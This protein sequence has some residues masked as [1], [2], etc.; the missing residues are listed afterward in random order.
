MGA[1]VENATGFGLANSHGSDRKIFL[2]ALCMGHFRGVS[3][4]PGI[5]NRG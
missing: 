3:Q 4:S 5:G 2:P 1:E